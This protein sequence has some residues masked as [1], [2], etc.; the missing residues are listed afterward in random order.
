MM[1]KKVGKGKGSINKNKIYRLGL[2]IMLGGQNFM[3]AKKGRF[4]QVTFV[5]K[6]S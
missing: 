6:S 4:L 2:W 1:P 3:A 5:Y